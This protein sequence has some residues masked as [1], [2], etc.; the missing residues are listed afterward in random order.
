VRMAPARRARSTAPVSS[1]EPPPPPAPAPG[2]PSA[3]T[4]ASSDAGEPGVTKKK[5]RSIF[6]WAAMLGLLR[7]P[8]AEVEAA[9][10]A[11]PPVSDTVTGA[12]EAL[13][14]GRLELER[15]AAQQSHV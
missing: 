2:A 5:Q 1:S 3:D 11:Q 15:T 14:S 7:R 12:G 8:L 10:G 9:A 6:E 13:S 4:V